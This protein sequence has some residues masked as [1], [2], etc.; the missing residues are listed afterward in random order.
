MDDR[1]Q[2]NKGPN[3]PTISANILFLIGLFILFIIDIDFKKP[4]KLKCSFL[5]SI[6]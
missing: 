1:R 3:E 6:S 2:I 4:D 5:Q